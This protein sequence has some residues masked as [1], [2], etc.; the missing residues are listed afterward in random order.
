VIHQ[1]SDFDV[2]LR[3]FRGNAE[4][5][6]KAGVTRVILSRLADDPTRVG[7]HF[8]A[9]SLDSIRAFLAGSDYE[10][11][12]QADKATESTI[13]WIATDE[14]DELPS[15]TSPGSASLFKKFPLRDV[16]CALRGLRGSQVQLQSQGLLGWSLHRTESDPGVAIVHLVATD[17]AQAERLFSNGPIASLL[18]GCGAERLE[19]P[20][21]GVN[22]ELP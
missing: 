5:R 13:L 10:R 15:V 20:V 8:S 4:A 19:K 18:Q 2:Y 9:G 22:Q 1:V 17:A 14:L 21:I 11:L 16:E 6:S 12:A 7:L 3:Q